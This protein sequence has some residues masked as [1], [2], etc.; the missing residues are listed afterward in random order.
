[1]QRGAGGFTELSASASQREES[2]MRMGARISSLVPVILVASS[3]LLACGCGSARKTKPNGISALLSEGEKWGQRVFLA[4]CQQCH[5]GGE[6]GLGPALNNKPLPGFMIRLQVR[7][8]LGAM[9]SFSSIRIPESDLERL[10]SYM[11]RL[12]KG[13]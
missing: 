9:P 6:A 1:M 8:G 10:I 5:P 3:L 2:F 4:N 11:Q 13:G 7:H 12:R